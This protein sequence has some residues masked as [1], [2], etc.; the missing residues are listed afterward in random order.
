[1]KNTFHLRLILMVETLNKINDIKIQHWGSTIKPNTRNKNSIGQLYG[2]YLDI[3]TAKVKTAVSISAFSVR[4]VL[5]IA[6]TD[7]VSI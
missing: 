4:L 7:V 3:N 2:I 5:R 1:M 6:V